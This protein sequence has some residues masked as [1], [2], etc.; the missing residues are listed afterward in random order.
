MLEDK[1]LSDAKIKKIEAR[2]KETE[3]KLESVVKELRS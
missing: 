1:S 3:E 2:H